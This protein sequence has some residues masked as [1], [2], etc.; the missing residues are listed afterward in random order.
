[1]ERYTAKNEE[2]QY[3]LDNGTLSET[4]REACNKLGQLEDINEMCYKLKCQPIYEKYVDN[5]VRKDDYT[6]WWAFYDFEYNNIVLCRDGEYKFLSV[7]EYGNLW[8]FTKEE[9]K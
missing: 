1:M 7:D 4:L 3:Y 6:A 9:L 8:A 2:G 5:K